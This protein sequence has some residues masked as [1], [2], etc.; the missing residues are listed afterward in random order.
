M[1]NLGANTNRRTSSL[2]FTTGDNIQLPSY[3]PSLTTRHLDT[4]DSVDNGNFVASTNLSRLSTLL[5]QRNNV[6]VQ[7]SQVLANLGSFMNHTQNIAGFELVRQEASRVALEMI[8]I[9]GN[10]NN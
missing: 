4:I 2:T 6:T 1:C 7:D 5:N 8:Q 9:F 10:S 3:R